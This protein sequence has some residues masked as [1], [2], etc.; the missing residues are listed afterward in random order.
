MCSVDRISAVI[1]KG[2]PP[3][4]NVRQYRRTCVIFIKHVFLILVQDLSMFEFASYT[5]Q[6][7]HVQLRTLFGKITDI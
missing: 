5:S 3:P 1:T 6:G 7:E 2:I 4:A